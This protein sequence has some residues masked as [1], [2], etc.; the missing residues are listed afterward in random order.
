[1]KKIMILV[2]MVAAFVLPTMAQIGK[3]DP[4]KVQFQSTSTMQASGSVLASQPMLNADGTAYNPAASST[5]S[6]PR[7]IGGLPG[8]G[9]SGSEGLPDTSKDGDNTPVGDAMLPLTL[10]ALAFAGVIALRRRRAT[11]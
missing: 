5:P 6:G 9:G 7:K 3:E 2:V 8:T 10:M 4:N 11:R 1:M